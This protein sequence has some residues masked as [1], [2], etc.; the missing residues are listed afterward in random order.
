MWRRLYFESDVLPNGDVF[1]AGGEYTVVDGAQEETDTNTAEMYIPGSGQNYRT[2]TWKVLPSNPQPNEGDVPSEVLPDGNV[3]VGD[4]GGPGTEIYDPTTNTWSTG[5]T[6]I[7][8]NEQSDE[9][10][11]VKLPNGDILAY[12]LWAS[13]EDNEGLAEIYNPTTNTWSDASNGNLPV[14]SSG[15]GIRAR[16]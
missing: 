8:A 3:F 9:E 14:L 5:A 6:E 10:A 15:R 11:W 16:A 4:I 7:H 2:G 12:D 13:I 1:V